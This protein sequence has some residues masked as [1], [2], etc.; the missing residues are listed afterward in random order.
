MAEQIRMN[1]A[2]GARPYGQDI[3]VQG[4]DR[5]KKAESCIPRPEFY[6]LPEL[7]MIF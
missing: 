6:Y 5:A 2:I 3:F 4:H 1:S 7:L